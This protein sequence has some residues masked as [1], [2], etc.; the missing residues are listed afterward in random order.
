[1]A[2]EMLGVGPGR[3]SSGVSLC[4]PATRC[5]YQLTSAA[6][7]FLTSS[8]ALPPHLRRLCRPC[9]GLGRLVAGWAWWVN[10]TK[11]PS[12]TSRDNNN[13]RYSRQTICCPLGR[14]LQSGGEFKHH[15]HHVTPGPE[16]TNK[17]S[18]ICRVEGLQLCKTE[19]VER[20]EASGKQ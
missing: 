10:V 14:R 17:G 13:C 1:M 8:T 11:H 19:A 20:G 5:R 15:P 12:V 3:C 18:L 16:E 4:T 6:R 9:R 2:R 7:G